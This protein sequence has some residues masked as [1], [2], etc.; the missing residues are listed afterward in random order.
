MV[1]INHLGHGDAP[2]TKVGLTPYL[3]AE[4]ESAKEYAQ[5]VRSALPL[6]RLRVLLKKESQGGS[7]G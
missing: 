4:I 1:K 7:S 2:E 6:F 5:R 3:P